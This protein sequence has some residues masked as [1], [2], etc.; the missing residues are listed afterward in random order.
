MKYRITLSIPSHK[1]EDVEIGPNAKDDD[2]ENEEECQGLQDTNHK[3][4]NPRKVSEME[5]YIFSL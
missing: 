3:F 2:E 4:G 1:P 5:F